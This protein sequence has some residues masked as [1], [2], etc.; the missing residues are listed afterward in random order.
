SEVKAKAQ[1]FS[2]G[3]AA[4]SA[5]ILS[6]IKPGEKILAQQLLYGTTDELMK[7]QLKEFGIEVIQMNLQD[8]KVVEDHLKKDKKI[9]LL[10]IESPSNPILEIFDIEVLTSLAKK[11]KCKTI[12]DNTFATPYLQKPLLLGADIS[13][14]STTK[15][16]NG[17]GTGMGGVVIGTDKKLIKEDVWKKVKLFGGNSNAWDAWLI[18]NGIKT[19][20]LRMQRHCENA[21]KVALYLNDHAA[22]SKVNYPGLK[23]SPHHGLAK[24][25]MLDFGGMVSFELKNGLKAGIKFMNN[26]KVGKLITSLGT[27][28]T[29][30]LHPAS[31]SHVSVPKEQRLEHGITD[32]LVRM[33]VGIENADDILN[34]IEQALENI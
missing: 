10:Y 20:E 21:K 27:V 5:A 22:V 24:K 15:Y 25:Q 11:Y 17:H 18:L 31:M 6:C 4:I 23:N 30:M 29:I 16:L 13:V 8:I 3:M 7:T 19:L 12:V 14:H 28:D 32:G 1:L 34:D 26:V 9:K 2:S 33:S